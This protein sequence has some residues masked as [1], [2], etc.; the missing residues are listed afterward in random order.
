VRNRYLETTI[1]A[2]EL[3]K[4][5]SFEAILMDPPWDLSPRVPASG[6]VEPKRGNKGERLITPE[7]LGRW[8]ITDKLIPKGFLFIW[9]EK[10]LI[11]RVPTPLASFPSCGPPT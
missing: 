1:E 6:K 7:E 3:E 5:G 8:P 11:P 10:E 4:L 2:L 9:T